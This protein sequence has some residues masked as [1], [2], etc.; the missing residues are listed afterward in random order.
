MRISTQAIR[1]TKRENIYTTHTHNFLSANLF[2]Q[3]QSALLRVSEQASEWDGQGRRKGRE[4]IVDHYNVHERNEEKQRDRLCECVW[5]LIFQ[6]RP[7]RCKNGSGRDKYVA[8]QTQMCCNLM[9]NY[10]LL[11]PKIL[12][13][14]KKKFNNVC[15]VR[16]IC[17]LAVICQNE[18]EQM[19]VVLLVQFDLHMFVRV[20]VRACVWH[21]RIECTIHTTIVHSKSVYRQW[22]FITCMLCAFGFVCC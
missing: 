13:G 22:F 18:G 7:N 4:Y 11:S 12:F 6:F 20:W 5:F 16:R 9:I 19:S 17:V 2:I 3:T 10:N 1:T 14:G 8:K 15:A 21:T